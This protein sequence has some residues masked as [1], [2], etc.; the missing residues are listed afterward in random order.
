MIENILPSI[1]EEW[2]TEDSKRPIFIQQDNART[3]ID[4]DN[5]QF[6][7]ATTQDEFDI[8]LMSQPPNFPNLNILDLWIFNAI[9]SMQYKK[10]VK[11]INMLVIAVEKSLQVMGVRGRSHKYKIS[12]IKKAVLER[13]GKFYTNRSVILN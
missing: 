9:Q 1:K 8:C 5:K 6:H 3:H 11:T 10:P 7:R 12:H 13:T 2:P 4:H